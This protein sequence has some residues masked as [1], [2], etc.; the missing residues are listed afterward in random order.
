MSLTDINI[1]TLK[2]VRSKRRRY[3]LEGCQITCPLACFNILQSILDLKSE[4]DRVEL[5]HATLK[6]RAFAL[7]KFGI[8]SLNSKNEINGIHRDWK[9]RI[10]GTGTIASVSI[11]PRDVFMAAM[12][13]N[14]GAIIAFHNHVSGDPEPSQSDIS[15]TRRLKEAGEILGIPLVDHMIT[16]NEK[17]ITQLSQI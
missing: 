12:M 17:Y 2:Q 6:K 3:D 10:I 4:T 15:L 14:A 13:N 9:S 7:L 5:Q 16:G 11:N 8:I 1:Y